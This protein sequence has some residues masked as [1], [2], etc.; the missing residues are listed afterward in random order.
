MYK[1]T[2]YLHCMKRKKCFML[3]V[4]CD[5]VAYLQDPPA[6]GPSL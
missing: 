2:L 1:I 5:H 4:R 3:L 6:I